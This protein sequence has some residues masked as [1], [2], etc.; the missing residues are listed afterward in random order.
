MINIIVEISKYVLLLLMLIFTI[1]TYSALRTKSREK[2]VSRTRGQLVVML[3]FD[4]A[5]F[6]VMYIQTY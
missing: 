1:Y 5:A 4:F 3:F 6:A 2:R